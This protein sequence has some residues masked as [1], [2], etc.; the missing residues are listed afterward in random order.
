MSLQRS[1]LSFGGLLVVLLCGLTA[2]MQPSLAGGDEDPLLQKSRVLT[3]AFAGRL[4]LALQSALREGGP[5]AAVAVCKDI[6]P[7]IASE[8]SRHSGARVRRISVRYRNP[9]NAPEPWEKTVLEAFE[10]NSSDAGDEQA[11]EFFAGGDAETSARYL[12]GIR[13]GSVC[14]VCHGT[15]ITEDVEAILQAEYPFDRARDYELNDLRGAFSV[16][17]PDQGDAPPAKSA[18]H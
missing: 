3:E 9:G 18:A 16:T 14:L 17:W 7:Q 15:S 6:A 12:K 13:T 11:P 1:L 4:Q 8:L 2:S 5:V 10:R